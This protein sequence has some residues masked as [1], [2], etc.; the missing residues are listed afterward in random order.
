V[1]QRG[2]GEEDEES[3]EDPQQA[4]LGLVDLGVQRL[5]ERPYR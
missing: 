3:G 1:G 2:I 4:M 5:K